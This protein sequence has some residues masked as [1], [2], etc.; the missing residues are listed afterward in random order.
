MIWIGYKN[1]IVPSKQ[2]EEIGTKTKKKFKVQ[3]I[4][5]HI[6]EFS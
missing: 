3:D 5:L 1:G 6:P 4:T 2:K